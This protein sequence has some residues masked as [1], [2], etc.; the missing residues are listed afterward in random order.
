MRPAT[1][2]DFTMAGAMA[3]I[4]GLGHETPALSGFGTA[5]MIYAIGMALWERL[6]PLAHRKLN[7]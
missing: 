2:L 4:L 5:L 7:Q 1:L 3:L 6:L